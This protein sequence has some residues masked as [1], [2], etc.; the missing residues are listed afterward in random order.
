MSRRTHNQKTSYSIDAC[1]WE[2]A[3]CA[4]ICN[5]EYKHTALGSFTFML[6]FLVMWKQ[7]NSQL[8]VAL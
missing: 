6:E 4:D 1:S 8:W 2:K 5:L 3:E 7:I